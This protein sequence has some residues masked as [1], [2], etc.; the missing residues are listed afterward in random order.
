MKIMKYS[1]YTFFAI[2]LLQSCVIIGLTND[3]TKLTPA[4]KELIYPFEKIEEVEVGKIYKINALQLKEELNKHPRS[5]VYI[6]SNGCSSPLCL[7]LNLYELYAQKNGYKLFM[8]MNG[9]S[10]L[11]KTLSQKIDSPLFSIDNEYYNEKHRNVYTR[12]FTN[13]LLGYPLNTKYK[14]REL[15]G[16]LFFYEN[17]KIINVFQELPD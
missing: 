5:I 12:F 8:V 2:S 15:R 14:E 1:I 6:F 3:F 9:Y 16:N 4:H 17:G 11:E 7:P 10:D 13:E